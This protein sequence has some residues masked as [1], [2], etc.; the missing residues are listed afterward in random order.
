MNTT[1]ALVR[2]VLSGAVAVAGMGVLFGAAGCKNNDT[3][4]PG[5]PI[6]LFGIEQI[7]RK[8]L[9]GNWRRSDGQ[10]I[11]ITRDHESGVYRLSATPAT[12]SDWSRPAHLLTVRGNTVLEIDMTGGRD[13]GPAE[14]NLYHYSLITIGRD[15]LTA[16]PLRPAWTANQARDI[17]GV[18]LASLVG[19]PTGDQSTVVAADPKV[20]R[21]LLYRAVRTDDAW[22]EPEV[23][24][25]VP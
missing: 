10:V 23:F 5:T 20:M 22:N 3:V 2:T 18:D 16:R 4:G 9:E 6:G 14:S 7:Q 13:L 25:R 8:S 12:G 1:N 17:D 15:E 11:T 19:V 24:V 21:D